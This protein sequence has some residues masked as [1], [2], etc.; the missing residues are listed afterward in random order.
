MIKLF[1]KNLEPILKEDEDHLY[2]YLTVLFG[3]KIYNAYIEWSKEAMDLLN[4]YK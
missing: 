1:K 3:E 2:Y 4:N